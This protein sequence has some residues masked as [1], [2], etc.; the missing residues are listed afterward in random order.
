LSGYAVNTVVRD[1]PI[2]VVGPP[3]IEQVPATQVVKIIPHDT[4]DARTP[5]V[6][7]KI[8]RLVFRK[9]WHERA[10]AATLLR[11]GCGWLRYHGGIRLMT[12][13]NM[14]LQLEAVRRRG[15]PGQP[16]RFGCLV[17]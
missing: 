8:A 16:C 2:G 12:L 7:K 13:R 14:P 9:T 1:I 10:A 15:P 4:P 11:N 17:L 3:H 5:V 6:G